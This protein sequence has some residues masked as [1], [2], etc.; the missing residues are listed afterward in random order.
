[1]LW[2]E[3]YELKNT[4]R[5]K[6]NKYKAIIFITEWNLQ[7]RENNSPSRISPSNSQNESFLFFP[8]SLIVFPLTNF[9]DYL[10]HFIL[11][12][13]LNT[14]LHLNLD[15]VYQ[16][17]QTKDCTYGTNWT[18]ILQVTALIR[19]YCSCSVK[20]QLIKLDISENTF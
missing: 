18:K 17:V 12:F 4:K 2:T 5:K 11:P 13:Y 1:M 3:D 7:I 6:K 19:E 14:P 8:I 16:P 9:P 10:L 20:H 15:H